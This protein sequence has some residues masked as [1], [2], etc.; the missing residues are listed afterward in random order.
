MSFVLQIAGYG[1]IYTLAFVLLA[2]FNFAN[3]KFRDAY[4][5]G[6]ICWDLTCETCRRL[7]FVCG[8]RHYCNLCN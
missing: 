1:L 3:G 4:E 5:K 8:R 6:N 7:V 2:Q